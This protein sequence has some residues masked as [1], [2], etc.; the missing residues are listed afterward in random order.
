MGERLKE[1]SGYWDQ[2]AKGYTRSNQEEL[3]GEDRI[4]WE[5]QLCQSLEGRDLSE[6]R[7]NAD[8]YGVHID[9]RKMNAQEL[10]F[11]DESFDLIVSRNVF[12]N[13]E[14]PEHAYEERLMWKEA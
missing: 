2:R 4:Y 13:L 12:W 14:E 6:A 1:I 11:P 9:F 8:T 7:K 3:V 5:K 10:S